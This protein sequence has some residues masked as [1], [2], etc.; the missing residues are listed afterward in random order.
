LITVGL[1][2]AQQGLVVMAVAGLSAKV[3]V[4]MGPKV[5]L[6]IGAVIVAAGYALNI[7]MMSEIWQLVLVSCVIGAGIGFVYGAIPLLVMGAVPI[8]ETAS[9]NALNPLLRSVGTSV[10]GAVS[11]VVPAQSTVSLGGHALPSQDAFKAIMAVG[12]GAA[13]LAFLLASFL[14]RRQSVAATWGA[15]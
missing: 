1:V 8:S 5:P 9:A 10:A 7:V 6:M 2:L 14:P 13:L 15:H 4:A 12:A 11:G 3:S